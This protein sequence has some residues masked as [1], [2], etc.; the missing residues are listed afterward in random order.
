MRQKKL[1]ESQEE[2]EISSEEKEET[3]TDFGDHFME[4]YDNDYRSL[5]S[6]VDY[7]D[8]EYRHHSLLNEKIYEVFHGSRWCALGPKKKIPKDLVPFIFQEMFEGLNNTDFSMVEKFV[9]ICDFMEIAYQ[10][11]YDLIHMKYREDI[12]N[13]MDKKYGIL[14]KKKIKKIF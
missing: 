11:A 5:K 12:V 7:N 2:E 1:I 8:E 9:G 14:S 4:D 6:S 3:P 10:K 13:E